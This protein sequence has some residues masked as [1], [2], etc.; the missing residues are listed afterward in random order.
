LDI[1]FI[2]IGFILRLYCGAYIGDIGVS[3]WLMFMTFLLALFLGFSKRR[4]DLLLI[5]DK[6]V[7]IRKSLN[8]YNILFVNHAMTILSSILIVC[9]IFYLNSPE[10]SQRLGEYINV[11]FFPVIVGIL[12]YLQITFV[13]ENSGSPTDVLLKDHFLQACI[14]TWI[15]IFLYCI[16]A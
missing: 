1:T 10:V 8:G 12:R 16:Y 4:D 6:T 13:E 5:K 14:I 15:L 11:S 7:I 9:Y 3:Q 2:A